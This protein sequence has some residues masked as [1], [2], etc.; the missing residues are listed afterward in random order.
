MLTYYVLYRSDE[1][2]DPVGVFIVDPTNGHALVWDHRRRAWTYDPGLAVR[3]LDDYRNFDRYETVDRSALERFVEQITGGVQLP[4]E[5]SVQAM[6]AQ[7]DVP[8]E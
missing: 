4:D 5:R 8:I 3:F 7:G 2:V 6:F 1:K